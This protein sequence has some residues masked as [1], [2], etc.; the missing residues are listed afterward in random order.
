MDDDDDEN[1]ANKEEKIHRNLVGGKSTP[2]TPSAKIYQ[3]QPS[4]KETKPKSGK[5]ESAVEESPEY[6]S[7]EYSEEASE[8]NDDETGETGNSAKD[9]VIPTTKR[10][11]GYKRE[12]KMTKVKRS[13][14]PTKRPET[15]TKPIEINDSDGKVSLETEV[16]SFA[17]DEK[18]VK[19]HQ[20]STKE[21]IATSTT[22]LNLKSTTEALRKGK[23]KK[24]GKKHQK[25]SKPN[26]KR[27]IFSTTEQPQTT[28]KVA[29]SGS[30]KVDTDCEGGGN[31]TVCQLGKCVDHSSETKFSLFLPF[32][33]HSFPRLN[34]HSA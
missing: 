16:A 31:Y 12:G 29:K 30:C 32:A 27:K 18:E 19:S 20:S 10:P 6:I 24:K 2:S 9:S 23:S 8:Y 21:R 3:S 1:R 34:G 25:K 4:S 14:T 26:K 33:V 15:T 28:E 7:G 13:S 11:K 5:S 22:A 17:E